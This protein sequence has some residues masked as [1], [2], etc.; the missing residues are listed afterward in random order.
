LRAVPRPA[1]GLFATAL[2][3][4]AVGCGSSKPSGPPAQ[5]LPSLQ[6]ANCIEWRAIDRDRR[7]ATIHALTKAVGQ[8]TTGGRRGATLP[9][10]RAYRLFQRVCANTFT[11]HFL[12]YEMYNRAAG[13]RSIDGKG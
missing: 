3:T 4:A 13:F 10:G 2:A 1:L 5:P 8:P 7:I 9:D 12:L 11:S 6:S